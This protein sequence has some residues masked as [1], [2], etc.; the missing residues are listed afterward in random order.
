[1]ILP[2]DPLRSLTLTARQSGLWVPQP[3]RFAGGY[4][5][6]CCD[7]CTKFP[8]Q[9]EI[10]IAGIINDNCS[11]CTDLN[12]TYVL[13]R[14]DPSPVS[15]TYC[16]WRYDFPEPRDCNNKAAWIGAVISAATPPF[17]V[18]P[19]IRVELAQGS[20]GTSH[21][22]NFLWEDLTWSVGDCTLI[23]NREIPYL[24]RSGNGCD[25]DGT[26]MYITAL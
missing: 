22:F 3:L 24:S 5:C 9:L 26:S 11:D 7:G 16:Y 10:V 4:P 17:I 14:T 13:S 21:R 18:T 2:K 20:V 23:S 15:A 8:S 25:S 1:M 6:C 19:W 12:A